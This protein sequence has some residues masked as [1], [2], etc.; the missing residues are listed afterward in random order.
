MENRFRCKICSC[1]E[2]KPILSLGD[3]ALTGRFL[4]ENENVEKFTLE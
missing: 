1:N 3:I 4:K 2:N